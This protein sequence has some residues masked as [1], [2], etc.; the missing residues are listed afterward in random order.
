MTSGSKHRLY[1]CQFEEIWRIHCS[2]ALS[3]LSVT[4]VLLALRSLAIRL[5]GKLKSVVRRENDHV[6]FAEEGVECLQEPPVV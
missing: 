4:F 3:V 6:D 2:A 1:P 5:G